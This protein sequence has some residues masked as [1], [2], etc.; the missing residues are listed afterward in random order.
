MAAISKQYIHRFI[1]IS[2]MNTQYSEYN[3]KISEAADERFQPG[4]PYYSKFK[5]ESAPAA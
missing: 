1:L 4:G 5:M 2:K 3:T